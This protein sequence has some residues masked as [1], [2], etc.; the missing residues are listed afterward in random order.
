MKRDL[1]PR[2]SAFA[3]PVLLFTVL[4]IAVAWRQTTAHAAPVFQEVYGGKD[5]GKVVWT[6]FEFHEAKLM[7]AMKVFGIVASSSYT[8]SIP[9]PAI[10][11]RG[12]DRSHM[13]NL[14]V[15]LEPPPG[16]PVVEV[17]DTLKHEVRTK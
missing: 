10:T 2:V 8:E 1:T 7:R 17:I 14:T 6:R 3:G 16:T 15:F 9:I 12:E 13:V 11:I 5:D 4:I